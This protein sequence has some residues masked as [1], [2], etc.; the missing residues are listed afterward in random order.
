VSTTGVADIGAAAVRLAADNDVSPGV[1][2][3]LVV[4][5]LGGATYLLIRSMNR[6]IKR[7]DLPDDA[8]DRAPADGDLRDDPDDPDDA[9]DPGGVTP[10]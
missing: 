10:R 1:L 4:A 5:L 9:E 6:Q 8:A 3:F 7:I 2:G